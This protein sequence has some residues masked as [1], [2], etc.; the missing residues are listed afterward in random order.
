MVA[1]VLREKTHRW[2]AKSTP[3]ASAIHCTQKRSGVSIRL[4]IA[5]ARRPAIMAK[6]CAVKATRWRSR[7]AKP[8]AGRVLGTVRSYPG[9]LAA[10]ETHRRT[11]SG[12]GTGPLA[13]RRDQR[14][15]G[16]A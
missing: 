5:Q 3:Q 8:L 12:G 13:A 10:A 2:T 14:A 15:P 4:A 16:S 7:V 1:S 6:A 9:S 11:T